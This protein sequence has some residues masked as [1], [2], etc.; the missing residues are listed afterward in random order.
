MTCT[1]TILCFSVWELDTALSLP[2]IHFEYVQIW[3]FCY[4]FVIV[5]RSKANTW[6]CLRGK[7][8]T[9]NTLKTWQDLA[10]TSAALGRLFDTRLVRPPLQAHTKAVQLAKKGQI[11]NVLPSFQ[12]ERNVNAKTSTSSSKYIVSKEKKPQAGEA[13]KTS[14]RSVKVGV[15]WHRPCRTHACGDLLLPPPNMF[16]LL[17]RF[18]VESL[19]TWSCWCWA[20]PSFNTTKK[21]SDSPVGD[22]AVWHAEWDRSSVRPLHALVRVSS[23]RPVELRIWLSNSYSSGLEFVCRQ[24][25][26]F[27]FWV[28]TRRPR[29]FLTSSNLFSAL[30]VRLTATDIDRRSL[31]PGTMSLFLPQSRSAL[32]TQYAALAYYSFEKG[33]KTS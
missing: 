26:L 16:L 19:D 1:Q 25:F 20:T 5:D 21:P 10:I 29:P 12:V 8:L 32:N 23:I 33:R 15:F 11:N 13:L 31:R 30:Q 28:W 14:A 22:V 18:I 27:V 17:V 9:S 2:A 4:I 24:W 7:H 6:K 3:V